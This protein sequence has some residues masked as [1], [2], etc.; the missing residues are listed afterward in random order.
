M[1]RIDKLLAAA[2]PHLDPGEE[3]FA[4]VLGAYETKVMGNDTV[5]NGVF[6]AT[7]RK[8]FFFAK[9]MFGFDSEVFPYSSVS[10]IEMNKNLMGHEIAFYASGNKVKM[11]WINVGD[12]ARFVETV[13]GRIGK[14]PASN[15]P[16]SGDANGDVVTRLERLAALREKGVLTEDEFQSQK[17]KLL[18]ET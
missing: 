8:V 10:S 13:K 4:T 12:V 17:S 15:E 11:K 9:R 1:A 7:D 6:I 2:K 16:S 18:A 14:K 3:V 5:K